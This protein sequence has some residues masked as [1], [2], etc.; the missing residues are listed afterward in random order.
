M[1]KEKA[2]EKYKEAIQIGDLGFISKYE[3]DNNYII[4]IGN[5]NPNQTVKLNTFFTQN[6]GSH[7]M[8]Y[9]FI[10]M[11]KY[12]TFHYKELN[13]DG[14]RNK[15][16]DARFM[17]ESQSKITRLIAPFFDEEA[18][19]RSKYNVS[20]TNDYKKAFITYIKNPD[21]QKN[22]EIEEKDEET[23]FS[24]KVNEPTFLTTFSI[25][26]RTEKMYEPILY[27]QYYPQLNE[28]SYSI[29]YVFSSEN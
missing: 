10:I 25:L 8:S 19:K 5:I 11:E 13:K 28:T 27:Y 24:G 6:L 26:F 14:F 15:K 7:D 18:K 22:V 16:I 29:N 3:K 21:D 12:P 1:E 4:K 9:E 23:C 17:I 20:F 2:E